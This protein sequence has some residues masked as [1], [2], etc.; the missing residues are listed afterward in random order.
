M[1]VIDPHEGPQKFAAKRLCS[2]ASLDLNIEI[3]AS[4]ET[5]SDREVYI[6]HATTMVANLISHNHEC[7]L[8]QGIIKIL[9]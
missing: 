1:T 8:W 7:M 3:I 4:C 5:R 2:H 6:S 9:F